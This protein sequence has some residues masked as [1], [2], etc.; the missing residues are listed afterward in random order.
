MQLNK[1]NFVAQGMNL[2]LLKD[3]LWHVKFFKSLFEQKPI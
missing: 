3:K 2:Y 1:T